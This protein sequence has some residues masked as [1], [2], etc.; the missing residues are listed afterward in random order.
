MVQPRPTSYSLRNELLDASSGPPVSPASGQCPWLH[1][2]ATNANAK[3]ETGSLVAGGPIILLPQHE[4]VILI[5][6]SEHHGVAT[7]WSF[8]SHLLFSNQMDVPSDTFFNGHK[9][10]AN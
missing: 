1:V 2:T 3:F 4:D 8:H 6:H 9:M 7:G 10:T 5:Q